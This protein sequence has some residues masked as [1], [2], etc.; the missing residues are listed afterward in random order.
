MPRNEVYGTASAAYRVRSGSASIEREATLRG[1]STE[2]ASAPAL[3]RNWWVRAPAVLVASRAVFASLRDDSDD[4]VAARQDAI[5]SI[6]AL[7][8]ISAIL[9]TSTARQLLNDFQVTTILIP[10]WAFI[11]GAFFTFIVWWAGGGLLYLACKRLGGLG[12]WR[13]SRHVLGLSFA[14]LA[15]ALLTFWPVRILVYGED[16]FR[17][18]GSDGHG[19]GAVAAW[20][21]YGFVVWAIALYVIG[22]RTVHGWTWARSVAGV[23]FTAGIAA[24]LAVAVSVLYAFG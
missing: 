19:A 24:G 8:S 13:R 7:G 14:P 15:L 6:A 3:E 2:T 12:S 16:L 11:G 17:T 20:L 5:V 4:A 1:V 9:A 23:A 21:F 18:G 10:V 22:V